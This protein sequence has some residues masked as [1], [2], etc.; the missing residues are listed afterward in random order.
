MSGEMSVGPMPHDKV[1][2][3]IELFGTEL[4][5]AVRKEIERRSA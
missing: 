5:P 4:A 2:R 3:S 1:M